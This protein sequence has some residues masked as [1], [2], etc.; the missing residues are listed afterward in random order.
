LELEAVPWRGAGK[1]PPALAADRIETGSDRWTFHRES[2]LAVEVMKGT[3]RR[4]FAGLYGHKVPERGSA[5]A[6]KAWG[7]EFERRL[8]EMTRACGVATKVL[9]AEG[10]RAEGALESVRLAEWV[11]PQGL[12]RLCQWSVDQRDLVEVLLLFEPKP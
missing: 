8:G 10:A 7:L 2:G 5:Q 12:L 6:L 9:D 4:V 1:R 3:G 11:R